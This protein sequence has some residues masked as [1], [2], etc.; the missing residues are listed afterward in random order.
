MTTRSSFSVL[1]VATRPHTSDAICYRRVVLNDTDAALA[2]LTAASARSLIRTGVALAITVVVPSGDGQWRVSEGDIC[3]LLQSLRAAGYGAQPLL[4]LTS[5]VRESDQTWASTASWLRYL[6][7]R[8]SGAGPFTLVQLA[9]VYDAHLLGRRHESRVLAAIARAHQRV[10]VW[11]GPLQ[12]TQGASTWRVLSDAPM[13]EEICADSTCSPPEDAPEVA[14]IVSRRLSAFELRER[15]HPGARQRVLVV[16]G[17]EREA[18]Q[19]WRDACPDHREAHVFA[20]QS[21]HEAAF[22]I[23]ALRSGGSASPWATLP[24]QREGWMS[25]AERELVLVLHEDEPGQLAPLTSTA[26]LTYGGGRRLRVLRS[27][28]VNWEHTARSFMIWLDCATMD[29]PSWVFENHG[30]H[31]SGVV[32]VQIEGTGREARGSAPNA[33]R[34][35]IL[36]TRPPV[37]LAAQAV[38]C[39]ID[40]LSDGEHLV[41]ALRWLKAAHA[42][43][44]N[45]GIPSKLLLPP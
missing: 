27:D 15:W 7:R 6:S 44:T 11:E 17:P 14:F 38:A 26:R 36:L 31:A 39:C 32:M 22:L 43:L 10:T 13:I 12:R 24:L 18:L 19:L 40:A 21:E 25:D 23:L 33:Q 41:D 35:P 29:S 28:G 20:T 37:A 9:G 45:H 4:A 8:Q 34:H 1:L 42:R 5:D 16:E 3:R 30:A 2:E